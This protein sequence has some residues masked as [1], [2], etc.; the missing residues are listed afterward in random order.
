MLCSL[1]DVCLVVDPG[2]YSTL[3]K[4]QMQQ[5]ATQAPATIEEG[6]EEVEFDPE[7]PG[8]SMAD[9]KV[10]R[11]ALS[12]HKTIDIIYQRPLIQVAARPCLI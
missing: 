9:M 5:E 10:G 1:D 2:S 8:L 12:P 3:V 4:L 7:H 11:S 6:V